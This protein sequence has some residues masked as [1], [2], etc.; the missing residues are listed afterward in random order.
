MHTTLCITQPIAPTTAVT[1][2]QS[3]HHTLHM[4]QYP[5]MSFQGHHMSLSV[6]SVLGTSCLCRAVS[7]PTGGWY[8]SM[9]PPVRAEH[10]LPLPNTDS[11]TSPLQG[12]ATNKIGSQPPPA[13]NAQSNWDP[14]G[15]TVKRSTCRS[16]RQRLIRASSVPSTCTAMYKCVRYTHACHTLLV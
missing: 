1:R 5:H 7:S 6:Q 2:T 15:R 12:A 11:A 10:Q 16:A 9:L 13:S 4:I 3:L 8:W 14:L